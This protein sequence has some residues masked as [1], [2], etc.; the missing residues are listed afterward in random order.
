MSLLFNNINKI[1]NDPGF[2]IIFIAFL[3]QLVLLPLISFVSKKKDIFCEVTK[4]IQDRI[5]ILNK[6]YTGGELNEK[7]FDLYR[8][9]GSNY[10]YK[11]ID[12]LLLIVQ[13]PILLMMYFFI[14]DNLVI[15]NTS[16]LFFPNL[17]IP[18]KL[19]NL[20]FLFGEKYYLNFLPIIL[21]IVYLIDGLKKY[22]LIS[23]PLVLLPFS[24][25]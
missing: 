25:P 6:K 9:N 2:S 17:A 24:L 14:L 8:S 7:I 19:I 15:F 10:I 13:I 23:F 3:F 20:D 16:F 5:S 11:N 12:V 21:L 4:K 1:F 22:Q 18:D